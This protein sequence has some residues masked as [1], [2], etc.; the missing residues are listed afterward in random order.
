MKELY[1]TVTKMTFLLE[2]EV[3]GH[4][5][6]VSAAA[7]PEEAGSGGISHRRNTLLGVTGRS[8]WIAVR[9]AMWFKLS[10]HRPQA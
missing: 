8:R 4:G 6:T 5:H 7:G 1:L 9:K 3:L 10:G 2:G